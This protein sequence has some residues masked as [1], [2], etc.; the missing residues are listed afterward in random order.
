MGA[1]PL[2]PRATGANHRFCPTT[3]HGKRLTVYLTLDRLPAIL[4]TEY[5]GFSEYEETEQ[6]DVSRRARRLPSYSKYFSTY[7]EASHVPAI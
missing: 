7:E 2:S 4:A 6:T 5:G 1:A 3:R